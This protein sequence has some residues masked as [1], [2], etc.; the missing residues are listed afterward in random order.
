MVDGAKRETVRYSL[1]DCRRV[2]M[3]TP[4]FDLVKRI[5]AVSGYNGFSVMNTKIVPLSISESELDGQLA[6]LMDIEPDDPLAM[7]KD[8]PESPAGLELSAITKIFEVCSYFTIIILDS[9]SHL[10]RSTRG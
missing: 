1:V 10:F 2:N 8:F 3:I 6:A 7:T 5:V 9:E 4:M